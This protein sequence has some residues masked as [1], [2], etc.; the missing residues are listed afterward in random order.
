MTSV[1]TLLM[2][3]LM[4]RVAGWEWDCPAGGGF[5]MGPT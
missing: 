2:H 1:D 5:V 4:A 3:P